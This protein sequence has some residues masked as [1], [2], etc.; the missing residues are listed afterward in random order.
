M[1]TIEALKKT[2]KSHTDSQ[3]STL[4]SRVLARVLS[5]LPHQL[6]MVLP[7]IREDT[8]QLAQQLRQRRETVRDS[9]I[10]SPL[11]E[12]LPKVSSIPIS[13]AIRSPYP[14]YRCSEHPLACAH[15]TQNNGNNPETET[16]GVVRVCQK[17]GFPDLLELGAEIQ[18]RRGRYQVGEFLGMRGIGR[19]YAAQDINRRHSV[20]IR[21]YLLPGKYF[22]SGEQRLIR[23]T[24]ETIA[25]LKLADGRE[26]DFRVVEPWEAVSDRQSSDRCYLITTDSADTYPTLR[27]QL[28]EQ[29]IPT[30]REI[31]QILNQVLQTLESLHGQ[32]YVLPGGQIQTGLIHGNLT[33][34]SLVLQPNNATYY[35]TAQLL[36]FVR[37]LSLWE[38]LFTPPPAPSRVPQVGDDLAA[39]GT[40]GFYLLKG[41]WLDDY[42]RPLKPQNPSLWPGKDLPL[43]QFLRQLLQLENPTFESAETAR[44][45]LLRLPKTSTESPTPLRAPRTHKATHRRF[46]GWIWLLLLGGMGLLS[47]ALLGW[48]WGRRQ[49]EIAAPNLCCMAD[50]PAVPPGKF[51]YT[52]TE[53]GTWYPLWISKNL[54]IRDQSLEQVLETAQPDLDL[55]LQPAATPAE[56]IARVRQDTADFAILPLTNQ[57]PD[58]LLTTP[59]AYDGLAIFVPFSYIERDLGLPHYL[60]GQLSL[61]HLRQLYTGKIRNWRELGGPDLPVKLYL[62]DQL[63]LVQIFEERV[64][65]TPEAIATFRRQ[66]NLD[67][68]DPVSNT[69]S[70]SFT[71]PPDEVAIA[72]EIL[73]PLAMLRR[74]LQ[75][76]ETGSQVGSIGVASISQIYGQCAVYPLAIAQ[77][78]TAIQPLHRT[79]G[80]PITPANDLCGDK[81]HYAPK[82]VLFADQTYPLAYPLAVF[83][84]LDNSRIPIADAFI[85]IMTTND[86]QQLLSKTGLVSLQDPQHPTEEELRNWGE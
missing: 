4:R 77:D 8:K 53:Q 76:F 41:R 71:A 19:L 24:F 13:S 55:L 54:V 25:G 66:W 65:Q 16:T 42:G 50:V 37:D 28:A 36:V 44:Q 39:L 11:A 34:D 64:L 61:D 72:R 27:T 12:T 56:A 85:Q 29:P 38:S 58:D 9:P 57:T 6:L 23:D 67:N 10:A 47:A 48:W 73:P 15:L 30:P 2:A 78:N 33:L 62:P 80:Q 40:I 49:P 81:G 82:Q 7:F 74:M 75:D 17:C 45:A 52:A 79:D 68:S 20:I 18:G 43:E 83:H 1:N 69:P 26:Q 3:L 22:N 21:E 14:R 70:V 60:Q 35:E 86:A 84:R 59:I 46:S 32:K 31:R 51:T 5:P 63:E